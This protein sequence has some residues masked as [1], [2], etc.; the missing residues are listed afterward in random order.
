ML[1]CPNT[2]AVKNIGHTSRHRSCKLDTTH[3][4]CPCAP[5]RQPRPAAP[6]GSKAAT[7]ERCCFSSSQGRSSSANEALPAML[8][9][10]VVG[11]AVA[12]LQWLGPAVP[13][14]H[15][16]DLNPYQEAKQMVYGPTADGSIRG[17]PSNVNP[18]CIST[19]GATAD[20]P[21]SDGL[22]AAT[23]VI[24]AAGQDQ[25]GMS[26]AHQLSCRDQSAAYSK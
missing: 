16:A 26:H 14:S 2:S 22:A 20:M 1:Q 25:S 8:A 21:L 15:A 9:G 12:A 11:T 5:P 10:V 24:A 17:C 23:C 4:R 13:A 6:C 7:I 3:Q 19:G 18:N